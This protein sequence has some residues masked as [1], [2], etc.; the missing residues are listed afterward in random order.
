MWSWQSCILGLTLV[1]CSL[2]L[3]L[4]QY[5][6][7]NVDYERAKTAYIRHLEAEVERAARAGA[8]VEALQLEDALEDSILQNARE[9]VARDSGDPV[10]A[11]RDLEEIQDEWRR[12]K[13]AVGLLSGLLGSSSGGGIKASGHTGWLTDR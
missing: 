7:T 1:V 3:P 6:Q 2:A 9:S 5:Y 12:D 10:R 11:A 4:P 8:A 13:R